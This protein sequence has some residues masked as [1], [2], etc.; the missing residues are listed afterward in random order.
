MTREQY[1]SAQPHEQVMGLEQERPGAVL[2]NILQSQFQAVVDATLEALLGK[3]RSHD[4][5]TKSLE[6]GAVVPVNALLGVP[7]RP[8]LSRISTP[9]LRA[10][11]TTP[12]TPIVHC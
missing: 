3:R 7:S 12:S 1:V 10:L 2:P 9:V 8:S 11:H 4:L 5:A 6:L